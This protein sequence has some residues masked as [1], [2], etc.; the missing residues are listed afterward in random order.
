M[1][2]KLFLTVK[3]DLEVAVSILSGTSAFYSVPKSK[4]VKVS[5]E[6][7][8][9]GLTRAPPVSNLLVFSDC[10]LPLRFCH[11]L[12]ASSGGLKLSA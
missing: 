1:S 10:S 12:M 2:G 6:V 3:E 7:A 11:L 4:K 5:S 8:I 9:K